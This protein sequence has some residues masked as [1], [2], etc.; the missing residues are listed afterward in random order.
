MSAQ[1]LRHKYNRHIYFYDEDSKE[2]RRVVNVEWSKRLGALQAQNTLVTQ[3][4][5]S[6]T[7]GNAENLITNDD[8]ADYQLYYIN[9]EIFEV[10]SN[11]PDP[12][13]SS[14]ILMNLLS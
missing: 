8:D 14:R 3:K 9:A 6:H 10:I 5:A 11:C 4:I 7:E 13:N 2:I 1:Q 12:Y